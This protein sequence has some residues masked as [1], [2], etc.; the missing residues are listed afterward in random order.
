MTDPTL[1]IVAGCKN[2]LDKCIDVKTN[3]SVDTPEFRESSGQHLRSIYGT[4][5]CADSR[6]LQTTR[7]I[8]V[9]VVGR[10]VITKRGNGRAVFVP[11]TVRFPP[12]DK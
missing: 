11:A 4:I 3:L 12:R 2:I 9:I 5:L 7:G 1:R 10:N 8:V 6:W